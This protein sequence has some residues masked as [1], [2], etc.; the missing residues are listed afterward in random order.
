MVSEDGQIWSNYK[1]G[2]L[3]PRKD[4]DGYL[5]IHLSGGDR[6]HRKD[7]RIATLV[8]I[9]YIGWPPTNL[10]DPT[11]NHKDGNKL[12]NHYLNLEWIERG[13]NSSIRQNK[14]EG[15]TNHE[16]KLTETQVKEICDL[17][18]NTDISFSE[19]QEKYNISKSAISSI[20]NKRS[21]KT[22]TENYDFSCRINIHDE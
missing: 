21:W 22:I 16:A 10:K 18:V 7:F 15:A 17:L 8:A 19:L 6:E 20:R 2:F 14:G 5:S 13:Q 11:I 3:I 12:N 9:F 4:K 1:K